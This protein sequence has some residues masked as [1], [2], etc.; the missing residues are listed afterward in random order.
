MEVIP[1]GKFLKDE[2]EYDIYLRKDY[3]KNGD[4]CFQCNQKCRELE[5]PIKDDNGNIKENIVLK[6][7]KVKGRGGVKTLY[8]PI[9]II[10][11]KCG[12]NFYIDWDPRKNN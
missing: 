12:Y 6:P 5:G 3:E 4:K 1:I 7:F 11:E 2:K 10:C 9:L 8:K